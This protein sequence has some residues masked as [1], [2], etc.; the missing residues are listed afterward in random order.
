MLPVI[1]DLGFFKIYTQGIFLV[2]AF[3]WST[4]MLWKHIALTS[5]KEEEVFDG[6]FTA[7]FGGLLVGRIVYVLFN[8]DTFKMNILKM[9]LINGFPGIHAL[10]AIFGFLIFFFFFASLKKLSYSKF[11]DY[12]VTPLFLAL[13]IVKLGSFFSGS[14]VGSQTNFFIS[15]KY[16][17]LDGSRHL[18]ALYESV[19]YFLGTFISY[20]L[21]MNIRKEKYY[22]GF[23][24]VFFV[25]YVSLVTTTFDSLKAFRTELAGISF[26]IV[27]SSMILLT[28]SGYFIYYFRSDLSRALLFFK[29]K[30]KRSS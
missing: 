13:A 27:L 24:L 7:L 1:L 18:T 16:P 22:H 4:F 17:N 12:I 30:G 8:F 25:W 14:E 3:F 5:F 15:L 29:P 11:V 19:F 28:L 2:L 23:N 9:I 26:D 10:S 21:L 6:I 20:K